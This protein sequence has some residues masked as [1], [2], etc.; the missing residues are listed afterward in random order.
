MGIVS[1]VIFLE[2]TRRIF[3]RFNEFQLILRSSF[4][5]WQL[6]VISQHGLNRV[7]IEEPQG[8]EHGFLGRQDYIAARFWEWVRVGVHAL[9][10]DSSSCS[11]CISSLVDRIVGKLAQH[12]EVSYSS[13][14]GVN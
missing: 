5:H 8:E 6:A 13:I 7:G 12:K 4:C 3:S 1:G 9:E 14:T 10:I 2:Y 11:I